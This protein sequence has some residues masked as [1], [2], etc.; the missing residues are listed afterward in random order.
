[1]IDET[2]LNIVA[3]IFFLGVLS[4]YM[5]FQVW[6]V[7]RWR[8]GL[9]FAATVPLL[10]WW[11][12]LG[13]IIFL[14][15]V[16]EPWNGILPFFMTYRICAGAIVCLLFLV[17]LSLFRLLDGYLWRDRIQHL[18][19]RNFLL[20]ELLL[21]VAGSLIFLKLVALFYPIIRHLQAA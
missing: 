18:S 15:I 13:F 16:Q 17:P 3:L 21:A 20:F 5:A 19:S 14:D 2:A 12:F 9:R 4:I 6:V 7:L 1:L 10:G 8:G 11:G